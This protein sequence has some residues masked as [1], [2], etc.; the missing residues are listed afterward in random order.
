MSKKDVIVFGAA[1]FIGTNLCLNLLNKGFRVLGIDNFHLG[2]KKNV[3]LLKKKYPKKFNFLKIN[4]Q[5]KKGLNKIK[6]KNYRYIINLIANSDI[7]QSQK[8]SFLDIN[9]NLIT[10]VNILEYF[11]KNKKSLF[12]FASTSA[13]YGNNSVNVNEKTKL[14]NPISHYGSTKLACEKYIRSF[15]EYHKIKHIIFRFP[16]V[17]GPYLTHGVIFDFIKKLKENNYRKLD[18]LGNGSQ[19]KNYMHVDDLSEAIF[20]AL[21]K[22]T[23]SIEYYNVGNKGSTNVKKIVSLFKKTLGINFK[24]FY[25]KKN[26]G[27]VGDVNKFSYNSKKITKLGWKPKLNSSDKAINET[28]K[29]YLDNDLM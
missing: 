4:V 26:I 27:W 29:W 17:V 3:N 11:K 10:S 7:S 16:N 8:N 15:Y 12:F 23:N 24:E 1:G 19:K 14:Q 13:I 21:K 25:E 9:L 20:V 6:K 28:L 2:S 22:G 18:I 5:Y